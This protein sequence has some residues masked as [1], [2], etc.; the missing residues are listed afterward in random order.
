LATRFHVLSLLCWHTR[1]KFKH[2]K[3]QVEQNTVFIAFKDDFFTERHTIKNLQ[4]LQPTIEEAFANL[5][6][7]M[8]VN[9]F[10]KGNL[11]Y[12]VNYS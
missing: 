1:F 10:N 8:L 5:A 2:V 6:P 3:S 12:N 4:K 7:E 11:T 9:V